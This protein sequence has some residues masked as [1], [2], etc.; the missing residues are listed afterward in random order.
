MFINKKGEKSSDDTISK[1]GFQESVRSIFKYLS[2]KTTDFTES[3][4]KVVEEELN[5]DASNARI[6][7]KQ[8]FVEDFKE[9]HGLFINALRACFKEERLTFANKLRET[10][11]S[12]R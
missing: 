12:R 8:L 6:E 2:K 9:K 4:V 11:G 7:Y 1:A 10:I 3:L 5:M